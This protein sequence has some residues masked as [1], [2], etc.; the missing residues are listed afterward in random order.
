M[1]K[2]TIPQS[3]FRIDA[4]GSICLVEPQTPAALDFTREQIDIPEWGWLG[5][6]F[7]IEPRGVRD[8]VQFIKQA[9]FT[10]RVVL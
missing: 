9:G 6:S 2:Q 5:R 7:A 8:F 4:H 10:F 3:D 1:A